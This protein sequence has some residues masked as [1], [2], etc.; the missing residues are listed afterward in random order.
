MSEYS[1]SFSSALGLLMSLFPVP[2]GNVPFGSGVTLL[3]VVILVA[4]FVKPNRL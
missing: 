1:R 2:S 4:C 3:I